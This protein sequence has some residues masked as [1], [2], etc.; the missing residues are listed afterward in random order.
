M[1]G[2]AGQDEVVGAQ[3]LAAMAANGELRYVLY[4]SE[5]GRKGDIADWLKTS[6]SVLPEFSQVASGGR[7]APGP[8][9]QAQNTGPQPQGNQ[10]ML[11]YL[12][13]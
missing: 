9:A 4:G 6:C 5:R 13:Q 3:D 8:R 12:C 1:G 11:L 2:F 7:P 10:A